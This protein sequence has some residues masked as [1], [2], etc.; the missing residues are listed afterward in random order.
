MVNSAKPAV[1]FDLDGT[2]VDTADDL[3]AALNHVLK[4]HA[5]PLLTPA[6]YRP[7]ASHGA[8]GLLE[9]GFGSVL[10]EY[11]FNQLRNQ[12]LTYYND[13]VVVHSDLFAGGHALLQT[14]MQR[15]IPWGIVTNKPYRLAARI[16]RQLPVLHDCQILIGGD[17]LSVRKPDPTPLW[18]AAHQLRT[19]AS[20]C[21]Y[22]GDAQR[23]IEAGL[24]AGMRTVLCEFGY[25]GPLDTPSTWGAHHHIARLDGLLE[26]L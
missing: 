3:G 14:L 26:L 6:Q 12:L 13:H 1:L 22:L 2:L 9:A 19:P 15:H 7:V 24:R 4:Q 18:I 21:W 16:V 25:I 11:D 23:D 20:H 8:R 5:M 17:S 10:A